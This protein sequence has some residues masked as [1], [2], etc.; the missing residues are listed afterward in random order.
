MGKRANPSSVYVVMSCVE[1]EGS[2]VLR[3]FYTER[4]A[5]AFAQACR[6][7]DTTKPRCPGMN[8][9]ESDWDAYWPSEKAWAAAHPAG[10][11]GSYADGYSVVVVPM[12]LP[13]VV[14]AVDPVDRGTT[15]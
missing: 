15:A 5:E 7:Y 14:A 10:E 8:A 6:D 4:E 12:G 3:G 2:S 9:P 11:S 13:Q 1:Y